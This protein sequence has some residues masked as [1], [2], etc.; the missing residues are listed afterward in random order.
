MLKL[1]HDLLLAK[2]LWRLSPESPPGTLD[3]L[4]RMS[5]RDIPNSWYIREMRQEQCH[6]LIIGMF[7][8]LFLATSLMGCFRF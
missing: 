8:E 4:S 7:C 2:F 3:H 6:A 5:N 1:G